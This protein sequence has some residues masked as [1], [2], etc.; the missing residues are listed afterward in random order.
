MSILL[1][2]KTGFLVIQILIR[3]TGKVNTRLCI[4][5]RTNPYAIKTKKLGVKALAM[6]S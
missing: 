4:G 6:Q 2:E 1:A 3:Q 5:Q